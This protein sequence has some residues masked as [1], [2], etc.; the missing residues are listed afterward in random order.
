V[1]TGN[2][3]GYPDGKS[4]EHL[5]TEGK[6]FIKVYNDIG[7]TLTNGDVY[8]LSYLTDA[9]SLGVTPTLDAC[10]TTAVL[11]KVAVVN[12]SPF[13]LATIA[14]ATWGWV[15]VGGYCS[16]IACVNTIA[17]EDFLQGAN[18]SAIAADDG[19]TIT[20]DSFGIAKTAY[21]SGFCEGH[22]FDERTS[23]G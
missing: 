1:A 7:S 21:A 17:A 20:A 4:I 23:I 22:L 14:D 5:F 3:T 8:F 16:K 18:A 10:A 9:D 15:Q 19:T 6:H 2:S 12:N 13:G 11:R